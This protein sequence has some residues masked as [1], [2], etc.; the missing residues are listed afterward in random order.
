VTCADGLRP[1]V[2]KNYDPGPKIIKKMADQVFESP[3]ATRSR[4]RP[5]V[6]RIASRTSTSSSASS[7]R[8]TSTPA[9]LQA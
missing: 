4:H 7:T 3:A 2:Y 9:H 1:R 5:R 6:E 8:E